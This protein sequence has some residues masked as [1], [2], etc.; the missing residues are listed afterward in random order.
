MNDI[1]IVRKQATLLLLSG[2][3]FP[4]RFVLSTGMKM[5]ANNQKHPRAYLYK[6]DRKKNQTICSSMP[7]TLIK[8]FWWQNGSQC[9]LHVIRQGDVAK[10]NLICPHL[11]DK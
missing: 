11:L 7:W 3:C 10:Q 8:C 4:T 1:S 5:N 2:F 6:K 9:L